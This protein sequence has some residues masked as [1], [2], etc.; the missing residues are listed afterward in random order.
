MAFDVILVAPGLSDRHR[1]QAIAAGPQHVAASASYP[2]LLALAGFGEIE[3]V[4]L[5][6]QYRVTAAAWLHE[7]ARATEQLEE[8]VGIE[9]FRRRQQERQETLTAIESGFLRRSLFATQPG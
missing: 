7:S 6:D 8:I 4:D 5:T 1:A 2:D 3:E 9:E